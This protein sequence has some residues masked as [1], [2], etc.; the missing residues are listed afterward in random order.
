MDQYQFRSLIGMIMILAI[1]YAMCTNKKAI[2]YRTVGVGLGLQIGLGVLFIYLPFTKELF[3]Y[4]ADLVTSFLALSEQGSS[5]VFGDFGVASKSG[6]IFAFQVLPLII[7]FSAF[8]SVLYYLGIIQL[9]ISGMAWVVKYMMGTSGSET[10]SCTANIFVGQTE[11]PLLIKPFLEDM[12]VSEMNAVMIGGFATIAGSVMGAYILLGIPASGLIAASVMAAPG[13]LAFAK[14]IV[15][16]TEISK[17]RGG[18]EMPKIDAG[19]NVIDAAA[20]GTSDGLKLALNVGAMIIAFVS[21]IAVINWMMGGLDAIVDGTL[22]GATV[23]DNGTYPGICP[24]NINVVL[25]YLFTPFAYM[26]GIPWE[27]ARTAGSWL[28]IKIVINEF[29]AYLMMKDQV[30]V[31]SERTIL[32]MSYAL[33]GFANLSSIGIQVGGIGALAPNRRKDLSKLAFRAMIGGFLVSCFSACVAGALTPHVDI[34]E[35]N[36]NKAVEVAPAPVIETP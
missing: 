32:M 7:F 19:E 25:G 14:L 31:M 9:I 11:A 21:I 30:G 34:E 6:F 15:P 5:I 22:L 28:G 26:M 12:T 13:A 18:A 36:K 2:N 24:S 1:A 33:C 8:I 10:L 35:S 16:E 27:E 3:K 4:L 23:R 17:T 20:L 29:V